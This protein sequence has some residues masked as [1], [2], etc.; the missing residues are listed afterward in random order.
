MG[1][2]LV[3]ADLVEMNVDAI[4]ANA[5]VNLKMVEGVTRAIFHKAG[6]ILLM[7]E[8]RKIGHCDVGKAVLTPSFN[9]GNVKGIIHAV[10][11]NY[12]NGKHGEE[13]KLKSAYQSIFKILDE[14]NFNSFATPILSSDFNYPIRDC[15]PVARSEILSYL[16]ENPSKDAYIVLFKQKFDYFDDDYKA[17]LSF[18]INSNFDNSETRKQS[19]KEDNLEFVKELNSIISKNNIDVK[20]LLFEANLPFNYLESLNDKT[21][22]P[23]KNEIFSLGIALKLSI[24][25]ISKLLEKQGYFFLN[26]SIYELIIKYYLEK[27]IYNVHDINDCLFNYNLETLSKKRN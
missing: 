2:Y 25:D 21:F 5:N 8:C 10:G 11:P 22:I 3:R 12:I 1:F 4:V 14:N 19:V 24:E 26:N 18:Y 20:E 13:K 6:D 17:N 23:T 27:N 7:N 9:I 15:Y 16:K